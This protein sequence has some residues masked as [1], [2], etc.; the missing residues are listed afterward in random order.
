MSNHPNLFWWRWLLVVTVGSML[1]G[2]AFIVLPDPIQS[3]VNGL[4]FGSPDAGGRFDA[5]AT[6]YILFTYGILGA[7]MIGWMVAFLI[8]LMT[9]FRRGERMGWNAIVYSMTI[10]FVID[11]A[12]SLASG[13]A[14]NAALNLGFFILFA[15][16]LAA[17]YRHFYPE[18]A[19]QN[20]VKI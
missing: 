11:S 18:S 1:F 8:I 4:L 3:F 17:T 14:P 16:P 12:F 7:V 19:A 15:I 10:W 13:F 2:L 20:P 6:R 5:E 9:S